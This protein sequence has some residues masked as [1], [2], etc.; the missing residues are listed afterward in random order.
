MKRSSL[1]RSGR[2]TSALPESDVHQC[3]PC[4]SSVTRRPRLPSVGAAAADATITTTT[5]TIVDAVAA[6]CRRQRLSIGPNFQ[7]SKTCAT[8]LNSQ[9][10]VRFLLKVQFILLDIFLYLMIFRNFFGKILE[11]DS[12][13]VLYMFLLVV[14]IVLKQYV[15]IF[16][17]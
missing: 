16:K 4:A 8:F 9:N 14:I 15:S 10:I 7:R 11:I 17:F 12:S 2:T 1:T 6:D 13:S 5:I 3:A